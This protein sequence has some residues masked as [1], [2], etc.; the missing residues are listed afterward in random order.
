VRDKQRR[1]IGKIQ[2]IKKGVCMKKGCLIVVAVII[3][4]TCIGG[5]LQKCEKNIEKSELADSRDGKNYRVVKIGAQTWMAENLNSDIQGKKC[6]EDKPENCK[7]YGR[8]Y[9]YEIAVQACPKGWHLPSDEEWQELV[10]FA[11]GDEVA[12]K[13]LKAKD[14]DGTDEFAFSALPGGYGNTVGMF[15]TV[16]NNGGWW[17]STE[18][19][20]AYAWR[21]R[22]GRSA[23]VNRDSPVKSWLFSVRCVQ[24]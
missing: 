13:K 16:G 20:A 6:Y 3:L 1:D 2:Q 21:R 14:F 17:S 18:Y 5:I 24:D 19:G 8:L 23:D 7:K 11:G 22:M 9:Y 12:G 15:G 4:L 10:D